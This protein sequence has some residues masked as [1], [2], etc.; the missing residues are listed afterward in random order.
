M[1]IP[2]VVEFEEL[3]FTENVYRRGKKRWNATTLLK[4]CKDQD[5]TPFDLPLAGVDLSELHFSVRSTDEFVWQMKRCVKSNLDYPIILDDLGQIA[6]GSH[7]ICKALLDGRRTILAY[8][9]QEMPLPD[10]EEPDD[11]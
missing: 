10:F 3:D 8:R 1:N 9:L 5:L 2:P 11:K 6:D 4:A 7:R